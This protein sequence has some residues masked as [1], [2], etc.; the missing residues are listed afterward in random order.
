[1]LFSILGDSLSTY[2]GWNPRG[3][4]V[5]Y[6]RDMALE[7]ELSS[8]KDT[9]WH[10]II[11]SYGGDLVMNNSFSGSR[12]TGNGFPATSSP[13]RLEDLRTNPEPDVILC[14]IGLNDFGYGVPVGRRHGLFGK[15][16]LMCFADAYPAMLTGI[17]RL[18]PKTR[19]V[20]STL[21]ETF[22]RNRPDLVFPYDF[23]LGEPLSAFNDVIRKSCKRARVPVVDPNAMGIVYETLDGAHA[24]RTGHRTIA[25]GWQA[26]LRGLL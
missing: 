25:Q 26:G 6:D 8:V 9:W 16:N 10:Q 21:M 24:T 4:A 1:M 22:I 18:L 7:N 3:Y 15:P 17:K 13:E 11:A 12:V 14:Y 20:C 23:G 5:F 19:L 2:Y